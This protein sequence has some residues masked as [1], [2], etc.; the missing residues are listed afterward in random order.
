MLC[1]PNESV[2]IN[3]LS[4]PRSSLRAHIDHLTK[5]VQRAIITLSDYLRDG[6]IFYAHTHLVGNTVVMTM[7]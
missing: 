2:K 5:F 7:E 3:M 6:S 4:A 1:Q